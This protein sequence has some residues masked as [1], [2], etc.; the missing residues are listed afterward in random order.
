MRSEIAAVTETLAQS[1][2]LL[3]DQVEVHVG[4]IV[5]LRGHIVRI[6]RINRK[7]YSGVIHA[8]DNRNLDGWPIKADRADLREIIERA[9]ES[10][11]ESLGGE[12]K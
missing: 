5:R 1:G 10:L 9:G 8:P 7:T 11:G 4:D 12:E 2:G 3:A 6:T